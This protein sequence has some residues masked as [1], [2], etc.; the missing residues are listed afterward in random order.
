MGKKVDREKKAHPER[1]DFGD[2][3][4]PNK[5]NTAYNAEMDKRRPVWLQEMLAE[6]SKQS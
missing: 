1:F 4:P 2:I 5:P 6:Q 3:P